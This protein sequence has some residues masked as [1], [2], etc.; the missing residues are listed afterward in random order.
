MKIRNL[1]TFYWVTTLGSFRAAAMHLNLS[2][3]AI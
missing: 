2:Q 3:P 1:D